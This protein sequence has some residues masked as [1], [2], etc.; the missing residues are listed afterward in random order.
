MNIGLIRTKEISL[1][2]SQVVGEVLH[3]PDLVNWQFRASIAL[4][5][6]SWFTTEAEW[7]PPSYWVSF[8]DH[9]MGGCGPTVDA[10]Y[11]R[12]D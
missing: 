6:V 3:L 10:D 7:F 11:W 5:L 4:E 12:F 1:L 9:N 2:G 8:I